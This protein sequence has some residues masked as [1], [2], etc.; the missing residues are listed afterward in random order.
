[1][2]LLTPGE[3]SVNTLANTLVPRRRPRSGLGDVSANSDG[4]EY[5]MLRKISTILLAA[6]LAS[7]LAACGG[8]DGAGS[9]SGNGSGDEKIV[10]GFSQVGAESGWRT[11]N[12]KS[13]Q[14]SA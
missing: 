12:T 11:A 1:V 10:L 7:S 13:I 3:V 9:G 6:T 5:E 4:K 8:E 14:D 2:K